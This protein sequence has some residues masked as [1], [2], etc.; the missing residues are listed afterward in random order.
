M[1]KN[2][3][4]IKCYNYI[5]SFHVCVSIAVIISITPTMCVFGREKWGSFD[6]WRIKHVF[7]V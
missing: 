4:I 2:K 6:R 3:A 7:F 1:T 5:Q